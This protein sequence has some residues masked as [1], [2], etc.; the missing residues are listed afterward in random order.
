MTVSLLLDVSS[1]SLDPA[2]DL[3]LVGDVLELTYPS[4]VLSTWMFGSK[5][6]I[7][8]A[9]PGLAGVLVSG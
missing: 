4:L 7:M 5:S 6:G 2:R 9:G 8:T 3:D 1:M